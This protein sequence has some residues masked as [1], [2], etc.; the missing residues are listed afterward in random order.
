MEMAED[1]VKTGGEDNITKA[2]ELILQSREKLV[3]AQAYLMDE[4]RMIPVL[5]AGE[6]LEKLNELIGMTGCA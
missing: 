5:V 6:V 1:A 3:T 4:G 2:M